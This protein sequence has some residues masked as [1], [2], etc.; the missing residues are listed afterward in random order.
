MPQTSIVPASGIAQPD[1]ALDGG[2]LAGAVRAEQAE[3]LAGADLEA[4]AVDGVHGA[5]ALAQILNDDLCHD[6]RG[7][8]VNGG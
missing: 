4:D 6:D 2:G 7:A 8:P 1:Q 5:V 3:D